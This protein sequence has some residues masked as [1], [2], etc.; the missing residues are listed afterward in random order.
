[1][2]G[3]STPRPVSRTP[4]R[5]CQKQ[6][7]KKQAPVFVLPD[8]T[9]NRPA[10][11]QLETPATGKSVQN[12]G[13]RG[14]SLLPPTPEVTPHKSPRKRKRVFDNQLFGL[15]E[16]ISLLLPN[17]AVI[18]SGRRPM[19]SRTLKEPILLDPIGRPKCDRVVEAKLEDHMGKPDFATDQL[20]QGVLAT[21]G[22]QMITPEKVAFWHG[23][24]FKAGFSS[25]EDSDD[26]T[27][28]SPL[29]NPFVEPRAAGTKPRKMTRGA[30]PFAS[31][32]QLVNFDTHMELINHRTGERRV[33]LLLDS[34]R[35][36][37][38]K[39]LDFSGI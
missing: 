30:N 19:G 4:P 25:D 15:S 14:S 23:T 16:S 27:A 3:L 26:E 6:S 10:R 29:V 20:S 17:H 24:S 28:T 37:K 32:K 8:K 13:P 12:H 38:P 1:M 22:K 9:P 18:G 33:E 34:Q 39:K 31:S 2:L 36:F 21:P 35:K 7:S 11:V 5:S